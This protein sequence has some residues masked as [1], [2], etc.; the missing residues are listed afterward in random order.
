MNYMYDMYI[1]VLYGVA[2]VIGVHVWHGGVVASSKTEFVHVGA[3]QGRVC[4]KIVYAPILSTNTLPHIHG[5]IQCTWLWTIISKCWRRW[6]W[7]NNIMLLG[8]N[9]PHG[10]RSVYATILNAPYIHDMHMY[11]MTEWMGDTH[12]WYAYIKYR[13]WP[14]T[15]NFGHSEKV[16]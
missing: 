5:Y 4:A 16:L 13:H 10:E 6:D 1:C 2:R 3:A 8:H 9:Q 11:M 12:A 15:D 14:S 7:T